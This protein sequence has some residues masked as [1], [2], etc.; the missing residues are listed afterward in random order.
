MHDDHTGGKNTSRQG[1]RGSAGWAPEKERVECDEDGVHHEKVMRGMN[2]EGRQIEGRRRGR[3]LSGQGVRGN[4]RGTLR[5][6]C[7]NVENDAL[8]RIV[9]EGRRSGPAG[10]ISERGTEMGMVR[11]A[12]TGQEGPRPSAI[13]A[14]KGPLRRRA[15]R[16]KF[17][18]SRSPARDRGNRI[19]FSMHTTDAR[20]IFQR[21]SVC[22]TR[23]ESSPAAS[24]YFRSRGCIFSHGPWRIFDNGGL[25]ETWTDASIRC[26][27][28][29]QRKYKRTNL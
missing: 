3:G 18:P 1:E 15:L 7:R 11:G 29:S 19:A 21:R 28:G 14:H 6:P 5:A 20:G 16:T 27:P 4:E 26:P 13:R 12:E 25:R 9:V 10:G 22:V 24:I 8:C 17:S 23:Y 2:I